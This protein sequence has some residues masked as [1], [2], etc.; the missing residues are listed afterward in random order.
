MNDCTELTVLHTLRCVG[1]V[2]LDRLAHTIGAPADDVESVLIDLAV[3]GFTTRTRG[4][5]ACW[6]LTDRGHAEDARRIA[7]ELATAGV[8]PSIEAV[9]EQF[10]VLNPQVLDICTDWQLRPVGR[11]RVLNDH[12]DHRY[13]DQVLRRLHRVNREARP[14]CVQLG[15][16]LP[17]FAR[18]G[19][20][21][22]AAWD[23]VTAGEIAAVADDLESFHTVW[24][25]LHE[26]LLTTLS[27]EREY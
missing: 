1:T 14:L 13:D 9:F 20:R 6:H 15:R 3:Q 8:Q 24:F 17:R 27:R 10:L 25:Q 23:R 11:T 18:Y 7:E 26:D 12:E 4:Q 21:L 22:D 2:S 19:A 5:I 16:S